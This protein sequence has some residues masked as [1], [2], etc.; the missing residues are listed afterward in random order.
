MPSPHFHCRRFSPCPLGAPILEE[1]GKP[2]GVAFNIAHRKIAEIIAII[3]SLCVEWIKAKHNVKCT[4]Q[5]LSYFNVE[6]RRGMNS[7]IRSSE[8]V[9]IG[10]RGFAEE[11]VFASRDAGELC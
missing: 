7:G 11:V 9:K 2:R 6:A 5:S 3:I 4:I 8:R 1:G 10:S